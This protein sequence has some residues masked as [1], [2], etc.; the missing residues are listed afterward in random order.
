MLSIIIPTYN[1]QD[2]LADTLARVCGLFSKETE[3]LVVDSS[4]DTQTV[5]VAHRFD[6]TVIKSPKQYRAFQLNLGA[7]HAHGDWLLFLHADTRLPDHAESLLTLATSDPR[8]GYGAFC[9]K[10]FPSSLILALISRQNNLRAALTHQVLGDNA[11]FIRRELFETVGG[12]PDMKLM[13][14]LELSHALK[15][16]SKKSGWRFVLIPECVYT[17]SRHFLTYGIFRSMLFMQYIRLLHA[18]G[19]PGDLLRAKYYRYGKRHKN[20]TYHVRQVSGSRT[21]KNTTGKRGGK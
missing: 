1:E 15:R 20:D 5:D 13:E 17:S 12:Y 14:D 2:T 11:V 18:L 8:A 7:K 4:P 10:F 21:C 16:E 3:I 19:V 6:V 9:K